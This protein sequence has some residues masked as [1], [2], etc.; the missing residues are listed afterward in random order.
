MPKYN[1]LYIRY[2]IMRK[3]RAVKLAFNKFKVAVS[4]IKT[5]D[6][7]DDALIKLTLDNLLTEIRTATEIIKK[8]KGKKARGTIIKIN[9]RKKGG[10]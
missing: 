8:T 2:N 1:N 5:F 7:D 10:N 4:N 3:C 9:D 6:T